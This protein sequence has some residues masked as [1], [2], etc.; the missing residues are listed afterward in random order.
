MNSE[1]FAELKGNGDAQPVFQGVRVQAEL[2]ETLAI[3]TIT[4][5]YRNAG[6]RNLETVYTFP[7]PLDGV[8]LEMMVTVGNKTLKGMVL[9]KRRAEERYEEAIMDGDAPVMLRNPQPGLYTMNV[10]NLLPG[11]QARIT[12]RY[13][14]FL[15]WQG[16]TLRYHLPTTIAPRY[17]SAQQNEIQPDQEP[18]VSLMAENLFTFRMKISGTVAKM[19]IQSPSHEIAVTG[20]DQDD[21]TLSLVRKSA[22]MDHDLVITVRQHER[23]TASAMVTRDGDEYLVWGSFQPWF[24]L[25][26]DPA[27]RSVKMMVDC[28]GSM[29]GD[30]IAQVREALLRIL[31]ELRPR[32]WFNIIAFGGGAKQLFP[33]QRRA[34]PEALTSARH[35]LK[36]LNADM[37]GTEIGKALD[38]AFRLRCLQKIQQDILLITNGEVREWE[39]IVTRAA[40]AKHRFFTVG[41][42]SS[43]SEAFVRTLARRTGGA[44]EL[45]S[46]NENMVE[47]IH[48][49][50]KRIG[51]PC[52]RSTELHWPGEPLK[53]FPRQLPAVYDGDTCNLFAW[54]TEPP[55]GEIEMG[56][57]L[58]DGSKKLLTAEIR[59]T[60]AD[61]DQTIP[62]MTAALKLREI[63][64]E[65]EGEE[66]A[67]NY[68]LMTPWTNYLAVVVGEE[69]EKADSLPDLQNVRRMSAAGWGGFESVCSQGS[70]IMALRESRENMMDMQGEPPCEFAQPASNETWLWE[71]QQE[72]PDRFV[73]W[74]DTTLGG[75]AMPTT[76]RFPLLPTGIEAV[77]ALLVAEGMEEQIV[78][79]LFLHYL[80]G[81]S[82][83][84]K[85]SRQAKRTINKAYR[86]LRINRQV[87][88]SIRGR[89]RVGTQT[90]QSSRSIP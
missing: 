46:P 89:L 83:G 39:K 37:G 2:R 19:A 67:L 27:P 42:G 78:I 21:R 61:Q 5:T 71:V 8:L 82:A 13:G 79:T 54:F 22:G 65:E 48:R 88:R 60:T 90:P 47:R 57:H 44:C 75:N 72:S 70:D 81:S 55:A 58:P 10:G 56:V 14:L 28:S 35:F 20:S 38:M 16:E 24:D 86:E 45:V 59:P 62:R 32:D 34:N 66:L 52:S 80:A 3:T 1:I 12:I 31:D 9:P 74:L 11:E 68:G 41:V 15:R 43:V 33:A 40:K 17:G 36:K 29:A 77:L 7:L 64:G 50:F 76:I 25:A 73:A 49:H 63:T 53:M 69:G 4:H 84:D 23:Q 18:E 26:Q 51:T 85:L 6:F 30:A 87:A